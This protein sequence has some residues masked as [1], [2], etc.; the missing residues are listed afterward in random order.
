VAGRSLFRGDGWI[1]DVASGGSRLLVRAGEAEEPGAS[2]GVAFVAP[3]V[4]VED[5]GEDAR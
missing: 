1:V 4:A 2:I 5:D 3:P